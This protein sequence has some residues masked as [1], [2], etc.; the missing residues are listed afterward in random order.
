MIHFQ[1]A[2][3]RDDIKK[4]ETTSELCKRY[5]EP[6]ERV[7]EIID[8][9]LMTNVTDIT[10]KEKEIF[11]VCYRVR[12]QVRGHLIFQIRRRKTIH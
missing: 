4:K 7:Q 11:E 8:Y 3:A 10:V 9:L 6:S 5:K 1:L 12:E 2:D